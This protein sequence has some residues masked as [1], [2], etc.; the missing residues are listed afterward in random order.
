MGIIG[1]IQPLE[2]SLKLAC[3]STSI[4][5]QEETQSV[6]K[7]MVPIKMKTKQSQKKYALS[8]SEIP[9]AFKP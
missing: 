7:I 9:V 1:L 5:N 2:M 8:G 3:K 4:Y 6:A